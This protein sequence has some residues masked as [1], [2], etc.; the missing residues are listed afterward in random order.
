MA[1]AKAPQIYLQNCPF[2]RLSP[3]KSNTP[4]PRQ[5]PLTTSKGI[6]IQSAVLPQCTLRTDRQ[7]DTQ[8]VQANVPYHNRFAR[9]ANCERR[10][11]NN[12]HLQVFVPRPWI[13]PPPAFKLRCHWYGVAELVALPG[14]LW[15]TSCIFARRSYYRAMHYS[16]KRG[17]EIT[18]RLS[19][20]LW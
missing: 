13:Y 8:M 16:A 3:P 20:C 17:H 15:F 5:T 2:L 4:I 19:V 14:A 7:T 1:N 6:G 10:A 18:C 9:Y 12:K 11:N